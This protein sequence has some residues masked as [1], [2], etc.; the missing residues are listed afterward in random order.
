MSDADAPPETRNPD[1]DETGEDQQRPRLRALHLR[2][3]LRK[4]RCLVDRSSL[5]KLLNN[6]SPVLRLSQSNQLALS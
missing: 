2:L 4:R 1:A 3:L 6:N 5:W